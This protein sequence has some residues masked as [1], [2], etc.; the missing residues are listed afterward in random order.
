MTK[1]INIFSEI[2][3]TTTRKKEK[4]P[5]NNPLSYPTKKSSQRYN[6]DEPEPQQIKIKPNSLVIYTPRKSYSGRQ[7][8]DKNQESLDVDST[9]IIVPKNED[10]FL[11]PIQQP[12]K[13]I[14]NGF[15]SDRAGN[16]LRTWIKIFLW[17]SGC[18]KIHGKKCYMKMTGKISFITLTLPSPQHHSDKEIKANCLNQFVTELAQHHLQIRYIWRAEKQQN[19]NIHFHFLVNKFVKYDWCQHVWNRILAK[20]GYIKPYADKF[21]AFS[22]KQYC[23]QKKYFSIDKIPLYRRQY[24]RGCE[25]SWTNPPSIQAKGLGNSRKALYYISKYISKN[26]QNPEHLSPGDSKKLSIS[27]HIWFCSYVISSFIHP[28]E[29]MTNEVCH[30]LNIIRSTE[31]DCIFYDTYVTV[32]KKPVEY[33]FNLGCYN[34]YNLFV[35]GLNL[36]NSNELFSPT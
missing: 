35:T 22:F 19:G 4:K 36:L 1:Q 33:L 30:D 7:N 3:E 8:F 26:D 31:P 21:S 24:K 6:Y 9:I 34:I 15:L 5:K 23:E 18:F 13:N 32:I 25:E 16:R 2:E 20:E 12:R 28:T 17:S 14:T 10:P 11:K 27:G 29:F